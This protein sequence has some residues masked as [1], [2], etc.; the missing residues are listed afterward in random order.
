MDTCCKGFNF[1]PQ[2]MYRA[3]GVHG[4]SCMGPM[5]ILH[6]G[7]KVSS[8][9]LDFKSRGSCSLTP[10]LK[11]LLYFVCTAV[12]HSTL[13]AKAKPHKRRMAI[14]TLAIT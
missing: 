8:Q 2:A 6:P 4:A 5:P 14:R 12:L 10:C 13:E 3:D 9:A 11:V 7:W 1:V